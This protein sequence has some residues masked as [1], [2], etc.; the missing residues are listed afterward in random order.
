MTKDH[1]ILFKYYQ[2]NINSSD[3]FVRG[4]ATISY[5]EA[6]LLLILATKAEN[7]IDFTISSSCSH[8]EVPAQLND[9]HF[10][11]IYSTGSL[12]EIN[13]TFSDEESGE[14]ENFMSNLKSES[15]IFLKNNLVCYCIAIAC[16]S[17]LI[18]KRLESKSMKNFNYFSIVHQ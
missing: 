16:Y 18:N 15:Q 12:E 13:M 3:W 7:L 17:L 11:D 2:D 4:K 5:R 9:D 10:E 8:L 1:L 14:E 6:Q